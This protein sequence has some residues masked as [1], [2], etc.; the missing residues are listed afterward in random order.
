MGRSFPPPLLAM[1][2]VVWY[3]L[4][5]DHDGEE[6]ALLI[7]LRLPLAT[8]SKRNFPVETPPLSGWLFSALLFRDDKNGV[9]FLPRVYALPLRRDAG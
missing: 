4:T 2:R 5:G 3:T 7:Q 8:S 6:D 1:E 9:R